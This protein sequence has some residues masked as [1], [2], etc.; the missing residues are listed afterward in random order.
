MTRPLHAALLAL[1]LTLTACIAS[2]AH[3]QGWPG[4]RN[5]LSVQSA[6]NF[7]GLTTSLMGDSFGR[8]R[9]SEPV[10]EGDAKFTADLLPLRFGT[11]TTGGGASVAHA[12]PRPQARLRVTNASERALIR[13]FEYHRYRAAQSQLIRMTAQL[14]APT[15]GIEARMGYYSDTDGV[16]LAQ[17]S[18][19]PVMVI[20]SS[21]SGAVVEQRIPQ[22]SWNI[23]T[24]R[25]GTDVLDLSKGVVM[26]I[27]LQYLGHGTVRMG[28]DLDGGTHWVHREQHSNITTVPYMVS[29]SQPLSWEIVSSAAY[30]GGA[31][32]LFATCG[33]VVREGG[34][35]EPGASAAHD[36]GLTAVAVPVADA[37]GEVHLLLRRR[38]GYPHAALRPL[39]VNCM[40]TGGNPL[41]WR[42]LL[43]PTLGGAAPVWT[44]VASGAAIGEVSVTAG[45]TATGGIP[46]ASGYV[47]ASAVSSRG[48]LASDDL[49]RSLPLVGDLLGNAN[50]LALE[51]NQV[52]GATTALCSLKWEALQ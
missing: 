2:T 40:N 5:T 3:G 39:E 43:K 47:P 26:V 36:T 1:A 17:T 46:L 27:D 6:R 16:F 12:A 13:S 7:F 10:I 9:V 23:D 34:T 48:T 19:G 22:A 44:S 45:I 14:G 49:S 18:T 15:A 30:A 52:G 42:L 41:R 37:A 51:L 28:F 29:G 33:S 31:R 25:T 11:L 21:V 20:R 8:L 4:E 38:A 35:E 32:D 24:L 50:I